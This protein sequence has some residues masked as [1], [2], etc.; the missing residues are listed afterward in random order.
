M[1]QSVERCAWMLADTH[2]P[3]RAARLL[4]AAEAARDRIR[5]P[6]LGDKVFY[7]RHL[8]RARDE[9]D[10]ATFD[11]TWGEGRAMTLE[12]AV[13]YAL[14]EIDKIAA[15][16]SGTLTTKER[17]GGL[18]AREHEV[19]ARIARGMSNRE[20]AQELV[21]SERTVESHVTNILNKLGFASR[22]QIRKWVLE[23]GLLR[24]DK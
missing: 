12:Q 5:A 24:R 22:A 14:V 20:I 6:L 9:L 10:Q 18:T 16:P 13:E 23:Q 4:G 2:Q 7:D 19:A 3:Q 8:E 1:V 17:P 21:V 15:A 11:A